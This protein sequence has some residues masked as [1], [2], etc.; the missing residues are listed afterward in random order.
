MGTH[1]ANIHFL[2]SLL[3]G[4]N[5]IVAL[6]VTWMS[7]VMIKLM[8]QQMTHAT[9]LLTHAKIQL[10]LIIVEIVF[11]NLAMEKHVLVVHR[12]V[13]IQLIV[14][15]LVKDTIHMLHGTAATLIPCQAK[16]MVKCLTLTPSML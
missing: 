3:E 15:V 9:Q 6:T 5:I 12:T 7:N 13:C 16:S 14:K 1:S 10:I 8:D 2:I 11:V 4:H